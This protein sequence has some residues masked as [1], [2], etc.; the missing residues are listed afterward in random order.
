MLNKN[1]RIRKVLI[2]AALMNIGGVLIFSHAFTNDAI[3]E[4]DPV[5]MSNFGLI[6]IVVWGVTYAGAAAIRGNI[7]LL[8]AAFSF[9]KLIYGIT[10][11]KWISDNSLSALYQRDLSAGLFYTIYG[12]ND[13]LFMSLFFCACLSQRRNYLENSEQSV[14]PNR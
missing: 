14:A 12:L 8:L 9:E 10:W 1:N 2:A 4:A 13:L 11:I 3:N 7:S 6:M 5:V